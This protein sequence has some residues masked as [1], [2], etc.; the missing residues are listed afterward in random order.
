MGCDLIRNVF[1]ISLCDMQN[2]L[3]GV[4]NGNG[5]LRDSCSSLENQ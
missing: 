4:K 3:E 2:R 5:E 1:Q